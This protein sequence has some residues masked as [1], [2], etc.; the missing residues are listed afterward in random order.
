MIRTTFIPISDIG[1]DNFVQHKERH[2]NE[3]VEYKYSGCRRH[4]VSSTVGKSS[5]SM[6]DSV[7]MYV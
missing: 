7:C 5:L 2:V 1:L 4:Q 6:C 3:R